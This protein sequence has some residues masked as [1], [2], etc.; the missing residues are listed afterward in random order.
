MHREGLVCW[1]QLK[2]ESVQAR[3][4]VLSSEGRRQMGSSWLQHTPIMD[5]GGKDEGQGLVISLNTS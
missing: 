4:R 3:G 1:R 5:T 2:P